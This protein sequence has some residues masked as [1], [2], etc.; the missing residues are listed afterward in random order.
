M[1]D[2]SDILWFKLQFGPQ[3]ERVVR[4]TPIDVDMLAAIACQETGYIW[5]VLRRRGLA[6]P[7]ILSLCVGDT[8]DAD[9]GRSAF[10]RTYDDLVAATNGSAMFAIAR[11]ALEDMA[12]YIPG[13]RGAANRAQKFCHGFGIFQCDLQFFKTNPQYFLKRQY[14]DFPVC[15]ELCVEELK[16]GLAKLGWQGRQNLSDLEMAKLAIVYNT[17]GY[18]PDRG[19]KQGHQ[20]D[21]GRFYGEGFYDY[22]LKSRAVALPVDRPGGAAVPEPARVTADGAVYEVDTRE[23]LLNLR[24]APVRDPA[25]P[26]RNV[27]AGLPDGHLVGALGGETQNGYIEVETTLAGALLRGYVATAYLKPRAAAAFGRPETPAAAPAGL[28]AVYM[29]RKPGTVTRRTELAG[30]HSLNEPGMPGRR[31]VTPAELCAELTAIIDWLGVEDPAHKR[32]Q[33]RDGLTF[34]NIYA[35]DY[36]HLAGA[37]LPR[38]WWTPGA[39]LAIGQGREVEPKYG[40]TI[41]E[42]RA[43]GLFRWLRDFGP[44]FGWRQTGTLEKLQ[45]HADQGGLGLIVARRK[46]D[47]RSGHIVVVAPETETRR[48]VRAADGQVT[49]PLQSQAGARNACYTNKAGWWTGA[50]FAESGFWIHS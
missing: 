40:A 41:E 27:K 34:C 6:T 45:L 24:S 39:L 38:V 21:D 7:E 48:A 2:S 17:G 44:Q 8:L 4:N 47:G 13:Y 31:G 10:P 35:H 46:E 26:T 9:R 42:V 36:C 30:A 16:R 29:P 1:P 32:Y 12:A 15:A 23:G 14:A 19:L 20:S 28:K 37:Y 50:Q 22:L 49:G 33:P 18:K 11:K 43:N 5:S 25:A 3:V